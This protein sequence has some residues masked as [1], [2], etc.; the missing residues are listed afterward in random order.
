MEECRLQLERN[1]SVA[2]SFDHGKHQRSRQCAANASQG[3]SLS[4]T[5]EQTTR[6]PEQP[7]SVSPI[8]QLHLLIEAK[9]NCTKALAEFK[10]F[11]VDWDATPE[12]QK[13]EWIHA[14]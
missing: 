13:H 10:R 3:V 1:K 6:L 4:E 5:G 2:A 7:N 14:V 8:Q 12:W 11:T 9:H